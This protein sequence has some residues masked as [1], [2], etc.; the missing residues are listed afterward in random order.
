MASKKLKKVGKAAFSGKGG[1]ASFFGK[2]GKGSLPVPKK[3]A[4]KIAKSPVVLGGK[5]GKGG[6]AAGKGGKGGILAGK[7]G[8]GGKGAMIAESEE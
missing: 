6:V 1:K 7:G 8:K 5:G 4:V 2:G 3:K